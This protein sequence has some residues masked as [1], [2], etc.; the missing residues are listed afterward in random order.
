[1]FD[2]FSG[3][4]QPEL[5]VA[6]LF[7][8]AAFAAVLSVAAP[9]LQ[10]DPLKARIGRA[11]AGQFADPRANRLRGA[12]RVGYAT[13][14]GYWFGCLNWLLVIPPHAQSH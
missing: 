2:S 9:M 7:A 8:L 13:R 3:L 11:E 6:L 14:T 5:L 12:A 1:M 10:N 4:L